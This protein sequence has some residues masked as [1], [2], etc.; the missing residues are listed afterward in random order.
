M[1]AVIDVIR[2]M[3]RGNRVSA[4]PLN[5]TV[6]PVDRQFTGQLA[7]LALINIKFGCE[8]NMVP[9]RVSRR[10]AFSVLMLDLITVVHPIIAIILY[11]RQI[12]SPFWQAM[13]GDW[14]SNAN[15]GEPALLGLVYFFG[16]LALF[17]TRI[18]LW[19]ERIAMNFTQMSGE[20]IFNKSVDPQILD[21][22]ILGPRPEMVEALSNSEQFKK[23]FERWVG[24]LAWV[25]RWIPGSLGVLGAAI[26][27]YF[28][29]KSYHSS[30]SGVIFSIGYTV[31]D[32]FFV[33][34]AFGFC[35]AITSL[36]FLAQMSLSHRLKMA[37][38]HLDTPSHA[39]GELMRSIAAIH[40]LN[41]R[42]WSGTNQPMM[43]NMA[44][45][46]VHLVLSIA[47][48][49]ISHSICVLFVAG[50]VACLNVINTS[51]NAS[52]AVI[53]QASDCH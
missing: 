4:R 9:P 26:S 33:S 44:A 19:T 11:L 1:R 16:S 23:R 46:T 8:G 43:F 39:G 7:R 17:S 14:F 28:M 38:R 31:K 42:V 13:I 2:R 10:R 21:M 52:Q 48:G 6:I 18:F 27:G 41:D 34:Q 22:I 45:T 30:T 40:R 24:H 47:A 20:N 51:F 37:V 35:A 12:R 49:D 25:L 5:Q 29:F 36:Q 50:V 15:H 3:R 53:N 32:Y